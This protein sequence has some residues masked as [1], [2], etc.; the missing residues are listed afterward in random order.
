MFYMQVDDIV[1]NISGVLLQP[2]G[3][4]AGCSLHSHALR[5]PCLHQ[6]YVRLPDVHSRIRRFML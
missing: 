5:R 4:G 3:E 6:A 2:A 1:E